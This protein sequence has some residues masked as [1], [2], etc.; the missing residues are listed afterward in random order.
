MLAWRNGRFEEV[1]QY[2]Y[3]NAKYVVDDKGQARYTEKRMAC[4]DGEVSFAFP[5]K[6]SDM[7]MLCRMLG[8]TVPQGTFA[9]LPSGANSSL[10]TIK[11]GNSVIKYDPANGEQLKVVGNTRK[12]KVEKLA[13]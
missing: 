11:K 2:I 1:D 6:L 10:L 8:V 9:P 4:V 7:G 5:V 3:N 13:A 12:P